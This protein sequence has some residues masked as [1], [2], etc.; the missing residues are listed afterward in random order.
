MRDNHLDDGFVSINFGSSR[1]E[2]VSGLFRY[3]QVD[4]K[5]ITFPGDF[6]RNRNL[7][8]EDMDLLTAET[9]ADPPSPEFDLNDD[10]AVDNDDRV[11]WVEDLKNTWFGDSNLDGE[12]NSG[13]MVQVFV[14]GKYETG[15]P[16]GW[17]DGDWNGDFLFDSGDMVKAFADGGYEKGPRTVAAMVPEPG[18]SLLLVVSLFPWFFGRRAR[19]PV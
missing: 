8:V 7:D 18:V 9:R 17:A 6:N 19:C 16:V 10:G 2:T 15:E 13:D 14:G 4:T 1:N 11:V 5:P 3:V 12:F